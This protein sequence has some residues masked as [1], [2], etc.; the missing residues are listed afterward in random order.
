M[1]KQVH[2]LLFPLL[3]L[4]SLGALQA[5]DTPWITKNLGSGEEIYCF[6]IKDGLALDQLRPQFPIRFEIEWAYSQFE[7]VEQLS[8]SELRQIRA[9]EEEFLQVLDSLQIGIWVGGFESTKEQ[10]WILYVTGEAEAYKLI[11]GLKEKLPNPEFV[12]IYE[13][14]DVGWKEYQD[15]KELILVP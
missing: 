10:R 8:S 3:A 11:A 2:M 5:Q 13:E 15:L 6:R 1:H 4:I 7:H 12:Q 9:F 14:E